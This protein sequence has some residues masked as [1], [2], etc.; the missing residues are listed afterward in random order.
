[1]SPQ[2]LSPA[3]RL[4]AN[5]AM[6]SG[7]SSSDEAKIGGMTLAVLIL[8]GR[9]ERSAWIWPRAVWR[10]GYWIRTRRWARSMKQMNRTRTSASASTR[11]DDQRSSEPVRP[12]SNTWAIAFGS[13]ATMP[14]MMISET[15]LPMPRLVICSPSHIR[16]MVPPTRLIDGGDAEQHA[17]VDAP[18]SRPARAPAFE[19]DGDEIALDR[20]E[21]DGA[22]ARILVDLLAAALALFLERGERRRHRSRQLHDDRGG[23]VGHHAERDQAH[24]LQAAAREHVEEVE[25]A[26]PGGVEQGAERARID[27]RQRHEAEQ[28]EDDQRAQRE[29]EPLLEVGRLGEVRQADIGCHLF[30]GGCHGCS[31]FGKLKRR[32]ETD[33]PRRLI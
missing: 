22:V 10:L 26:A 9:C 32:R 29:P 31:T 20:A 5:W 4:P 17:R 7:I 21:E 14:A 11:H 16:N 23:D 6:V 30:G 8:S 13:S 28:P 24:P 2:V 3:T 18:P 27:A 1:M 19:A 15:P 25:H 33:A 12:L